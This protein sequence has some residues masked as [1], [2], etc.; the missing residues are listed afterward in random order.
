MRKNRLIVLMLA[1]LLVFSI[2]AVAAQDPTVIR[3]WTGSSSPVENEFKEAQ[4]AAF[5]EANPDVDVELQ[6]LPS[7]DDQL[8]A[9]FASGDY[10][11]VFTVN[12][13]NFATQVDSGVIA[14]GNDMIE[15]L[16]DFYPSLLAPFSVDGQVYCAPKD[17]STLALFYN[18]DLFDA[19][20]VAYP[21]AEWTWEDL[22]NAAQT[23][24]LG[25]TVGI[26]IAPDRNR[27]MAFLYANGG[28]AFDA[29]GNVVINSPE[30]VAS[31]EYYA[32]FQE[33]GTGNTPSNLD[34]GWNGEAF[35][36]GNAA[37]TVEGNWGIGYL[38]ETFPDLNWGV[39]ELPTAPSGEKST[40]AFT[41]CWAVG[42]NAEGATADAAWRLVNFFTNEAGATSVAEAGFGVMPA[43]QSVGDLWLETRGEE[44]APFVTGAEYAFTPSTSLGFADFVT[45]IDTGMNEVLAGDRTA[46]EVLDEAAEVGTEIQAE[47]SGG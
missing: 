32:S 1:L 31:L 7:Y 26:S 29:D 3:V 4:V 5:E 8:Q 14:N 37:M 46:Q 34:A 17:F 44:F 6:I 38:Q 22:T 10:P 25:D 24:T 36:R 12:Q 18:K 42:A 9:A 47:M 45:V 30:A 27:W 20:G 40:L 21:T 2:S 16:D 33:A 41:E 19:A 15:N 11:E 35:G 28:A 13:F 23:L 39:A 43:R